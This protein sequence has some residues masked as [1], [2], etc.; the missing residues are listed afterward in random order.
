MPVNVVIQNTQGGYPSALVRVA[1]RKKGSAALLALLLGGFG[2]H[3]FYL[4]E[5][6]M[7][8]IYLMFCWT[9]LPAMVA[10]LEALFLLMM[11]EREFDMKYNVGIR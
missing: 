7:G 1:D 10:F 4:G 3:R 9:L 11:S 6:V 5:T 2:V 8:V